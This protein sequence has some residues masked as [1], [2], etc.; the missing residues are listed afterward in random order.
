MRQLLAMGLLALIV[1]AARAESI[2]EEGFLAALGDEHAAAR[3]LKEGLGRAEA[4]RRRAG[5]L[6]N[7]RVEF[8]REEP[9][10]SPRVTNWTVAWVPPLDGRYRLGKEA[11][12]K[13]LAAAHERLGLD[14]AALRREARGAF[15]DWS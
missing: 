8:W 2:G 4:T 13:G 10:A 1:P 3:A 12:E 7:P 5:T 6:A 9:N 15:A 11:A 14:M